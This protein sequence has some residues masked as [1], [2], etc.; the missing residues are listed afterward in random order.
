MPRIASPPSSGGS[1]AATSERKKRSE[2]RKMNGN[3][4]SS[5]CAKSLPTCVF[6]WALAIASPP[7]LTSC[8]AEKRLSISL[9]SLDRRIVRQRLE[10]RDHVRRAPVARHHRRVVCGVEARD[11]R[12]VGLRPELR[13]D[14][15]DSLSRG[16]AADVTARDQRDDAGIELAPGR[17][18]EAVGRLDALRGGVIGTVRAQ[19]ARHAGAEHA[20]NHGP[21]HR[22]EQHAASV[23]VCECRELFEHGHAF[24]LVSGDAPGHEDVSG[25]GELSS[26]RPQSPR[27]EGRGA[28]RAVPA[29]GRARRRCACLTHPASG[30]GAWCAS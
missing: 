27:C 4:S 24:S 9:A 14:T 29:L 6:T 30:R 23:G 7:S 1:S 16:G 2:S 18:L 20:G 5:A 19:M 13:R 25:W 8:W 21:D 15:S 11:T 17:G 28:A 12:H 3:A 26:P 10:V 22:H